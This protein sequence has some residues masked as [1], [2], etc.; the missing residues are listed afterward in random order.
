VLN[1]KRF[2]NCNC[3]KIYLLAVLLKKKT[4]HKFILVHH[5]YNHSNA[6]R[7]H[8][9]YVGI[10]AIKFP[11]SLACNSLQVRQMDSNTN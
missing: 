6:D 10:M 2:K 8:T 7:T 9:V 1:L 5:N 4:I 11:M 3:N